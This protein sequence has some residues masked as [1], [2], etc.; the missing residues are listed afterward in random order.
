MAIHFRTSEELNDS[1]LN[2][3][4]AY[5]IDLNETDPTKIE[6]QIRKVTSD[7]AGG[8]FV[9]RLLELK[10]DAIEIM[11]H[12][13]IL[14][15]PS[16]AEYARGRGGRARE[17][18]AAKQFK[19]KEAVS[20]VEMLSKTRKTLL[21]EELRLICSNSNKIFTYFTYEELENAISYLTSPAIGVKI[22]DGSMMW[23][24]FSEYNRL[25]GYL[26]KYHYS[27]LFEFLGLSPNATSNTIQAKIDEIYKSTFN[28]R[29]LIYRQSVA[30]LCA[31]AKSILLRS[32]E[33]FREYIKYL[34]LKH[35]VWDNLRM[36]QNYGF[37][38]ITLS[39]YHYFI[40]RITSTLRNSTSEASQML[41]YGC[42]YYKILISPIIEDAKQSEM[43][44]F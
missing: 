40:S 33:S 23:I 17:A 16:T 38:T 35:E 37:G 19:L 9:R 4:I 14:I 2:Y 5:K 44:H 12:D 32:D 8:V 42:K 1:Q 20:F 43:N 36:R 11:C 28:M 3:F 30:S 41:S 10:T 39:E 29:D 21:K 6:A 26:N 31:M 7:P 25:E 34:Q 27:N 24:P 22:V 15:N 13:S 18:Q